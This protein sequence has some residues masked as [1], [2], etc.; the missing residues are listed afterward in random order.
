MA[1]A[2]IP[3]PD[4][5]LPRREPAIALPAYRYVPGLQ[6]HP[7]RSEEGHHHSDTL[8][9][10][11]PLWSSGLRWSEH[12]LFRH[13]CDLFDHRYP[14]EAHEVWEELWHAVPR[15]TPDRERLQLLIQASACCLKVH[16]GQLVPAQTLL[17]RCRER[18]SRF[19]D[20]VVDSARLL[21]DLRDFIGG[22]IWP[23]I[24]EV[25]RPLG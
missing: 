22:G 13:A 10:I 9:T 18:Q 17:E 14:W 16:C 23:V 21:T 12:T 2:P 4:T 11:V 3:P 7:W 25:E 15:A 6:P 24:T 1:T 19:V 8:P 20:E 5:S